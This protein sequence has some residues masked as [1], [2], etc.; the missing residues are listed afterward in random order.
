MWQSF[1]ELIPI[2]VLI[3]AIFNLVVYWIAFKINI[4]KL[5]RFIKNYS[6][7]SSRLC[8]IL[9]W[10]VI[11]LG[12][13]LSILIFIGLTDILLRKGMRNPLFVAVVIEYLFPVFVFH[14]F[15]E[16]GISIANLKKRG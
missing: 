12:I 8:V 10:I 14:V 3:A 5:R 7:T 6:N 1:H 2:I 9:A 11:T 4:K 13:I 16:L 15:T